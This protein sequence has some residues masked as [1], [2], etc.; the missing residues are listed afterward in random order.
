MKQ[1]KGVT[2]PSRLNGFEPLPRKKAPTM[3]ADMSSKAK[4]VWRRVGWA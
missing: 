2:A 1:R 3:P 4:A